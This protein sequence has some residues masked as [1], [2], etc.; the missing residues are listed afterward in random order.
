VDG[1][2]PVA[3]E[4]AAGDGGGMS[5]WGRERDRRSI[6]TCNGNGGAMREIRCRVTR[7]PFDDAPAMVKMKWTVP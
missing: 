1:K 6:F 5:S 3:A 7:L 2:K 4:R